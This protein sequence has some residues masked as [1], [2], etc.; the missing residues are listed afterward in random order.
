M[1]REAI[2]CLKLMLRE[3]AEFRSGQWETIDLALRNKRVLIVQKPG[4]GKSV[5][6]FTATKILRDAGKGPIILI[7]E[8]EIC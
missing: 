3:L 5:V 6:Y 4:W 1:Y 7:L 2:K 8:C